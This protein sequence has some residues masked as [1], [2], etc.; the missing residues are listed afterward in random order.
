VPCTS[1]TRARHLKNQC[2]A[3]EIA[4]DPHPSLRFENIA[5]FSYFYR[6]APNSLHPKVRFRPPPCHHRIGSGAH[7]PLSTS[8]PLNFLQDQNQLLASFQKDIQPTNSLELALVEQMAHA[9]ALFRATVENAKNIETN[10][11]S[12]KK[13]LLKNGR[14]ALACQNR[15]HDAYRRLLAA[16]RDFAPSDAE[17]ES[18]PLA[19][20]TLAANQ[21]PDSQQLNP[22]QAPNHNQAPNLNQAPNPH[23][24]GVRAV[25]AHPRR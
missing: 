8:T 22:N 9:H 10:E 18:A 17:S 20:R 2:Q 7:Y 3:R 13:E 21:R 1:K 4:T 6:L 5:N 19:P 23:Q 16:R 25:E 11:D 14:L 24:S 15:F 12:G